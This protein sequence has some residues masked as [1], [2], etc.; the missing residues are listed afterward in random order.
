MAD[1]GLTQSLVLSTTGIFILYLITMCIGP[2]VDLFVELA[3]TLP[4]Q[5]TWAAK[6]MTGLMVF[7]TW[8]Y[9][10]IVIIAFIFCVWPFIYLWKR[11]R[12][13][14]VEVSDAAFYRGW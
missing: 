10:M 12:Y 14:D 2:V 7:G 5:H 4:I 1:P 6:L 8:F 11:H 9:Y 13:M 3:A